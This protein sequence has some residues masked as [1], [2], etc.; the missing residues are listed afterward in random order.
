MPGV[1]T[2]GIDLG[3]TSSHLCSLN[4]DGQILAREQIHTTPNA[5]HEH[6]NG[7][8]RA[9]VV[10]EAGTQS[11]WVSRLL[12]QLGHD[13]IIA[14]ARQLALIHSSRRKHDQLDAE[15]LARLVRVDV[16]L[17]APVKHRSERAQ[18]DLTVIRTRDELVKTRTG[19]INHVRGVLKTFGIKAP[20]VSTAAFHH[21]AQAFVP[22]NLEPALVPVLESLT[23]VGEQIKQLD[24]RIEKL[25]R[26]DYP[27]TRLLMQVKGVGTLIALAFVLTIEDPRRFRRSREVGSYLGL[28]PALDQSGRSNPQLGIT[29]Q[30]NIL[31]RKLLVQAAQYIVGPFGVDSDLRRYGHA[32]AERGGGVAKK[33]ALIAVARKLAVLLHHLWVTGEVYEPLHNS[34]ASA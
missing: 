27:E 23:S 10:L 4:D 13:V 17:L 12:E 19:M 31:L 9:Q 7:L 28:T 16:S 18:L 29:K 1:A 2:I 26:E 15:R 25:A 30:G 34:K 8:P 32:I 11:P 3:D 33:R 20:T 5:F 6:F 22:T 21:K 24:R 14:N